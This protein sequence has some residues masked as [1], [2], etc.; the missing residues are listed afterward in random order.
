MKQR[1]YKSMFIDK[2]YRKKVKDDEEILVMELK[3]PLAIAFI[4][5]DYTLE[6]IKNSCSYKEDYIDLIAAG[7]T[8]EN[9]AD[10]IKAFKRFVNILVKSLGTDITIDWR[11]EYTKTIEVAD[12]GG[13]LE[14][15][16]TI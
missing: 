2:V 4:S 15:K 3:I 8:E 16:F 12:R 9:F 5:K 14:Y 10:N 13:D 11:D 6:D 7:W 1:K